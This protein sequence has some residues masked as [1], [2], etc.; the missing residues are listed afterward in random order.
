MDLIPFAVQG[1]LYKRIKS[2]YFE[3]IHIIIFKLNLDNIYYYV[4]KPVPK[5]SIEISLE[6][7]MC[8]NDRIL[9]WIKFYC[10]LKVHTAGTKQEF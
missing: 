6:S 3:W 9:F 4:F 2:K 1:Q 7:C 8:T 10:W 5:D